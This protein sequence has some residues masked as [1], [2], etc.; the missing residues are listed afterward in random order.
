MRLIVN[1]CKEKACIVM[2][3]SKCADFILNETTKKYVLINNQCQE[4]YKNCIEM[5]INKCGHFIPLDATK[6]VYM[7]PKLKN[8]KK[9][10]EIAMNG[11]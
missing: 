6:N 7:I 3:P 4:S 1:S 2:F 8:A 11:Y 5:N 10:I 9:Q